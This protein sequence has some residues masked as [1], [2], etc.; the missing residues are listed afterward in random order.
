MAKKALTSNVIVKLIVGAGQA[1]P[2]P[3]VGPALGSKGVKSMLF[4]KEFNARTDNYITGTPIPARI[5]VYP[6]RSFTFDIRTPPTAH[7]LMTLAGAKEVRGR[8]RGAGNTRGPKQAEEKR[9]RSNVKAAASGNS[10][11]TE[12]GTISLKHVYE[13][14]KIKQSEWR[15]SALSLKGLVKS[16]VW[17]A[18]SMGITVVP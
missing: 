15:L 17:Q 7:F 1:S 18:G 11:L 10:A 2:S 16:I 14:A 6:D 3:P 9:A 5:T 8:I 12:L 13:I 4:V